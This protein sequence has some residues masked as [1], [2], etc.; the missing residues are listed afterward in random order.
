MSNE[1]L[2]TFPA[3]ATTQARQHVGMDDYD[4]ANITAIRNA[5]DAEK[6]NPSA[7]PRQAYTM[8]Q[9]NAACKVEVTRESRKACV[10]A[11]LR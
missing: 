6:K 2:G 8:V 10:E 5:W 3:S 4:D 9:A 1:N 7:S 11:L